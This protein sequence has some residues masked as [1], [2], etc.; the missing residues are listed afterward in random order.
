MEITSEIASEYLAMTRSQSTGG[1]N[2]KERE[3]IL[4]KLTW[5]ADTINL[6]SGGCRVLDKWYPRAGR[7]DEPW[8][9]EEITVQY[10][11]TTAAARALEQKIEK[12]LDMARNSGKLNPRDKLVYIEFAPD[13]TES[14]WRS[15]VRDGLVSLT[16]RMMKTWN[17]GRLELRLV[18]QR[19]NWWE[20]AA[21][22]MP[23]TNGN[24]TDVSVGINVYTCSA[25]ASGSS[26]N[27]R[28]D[29]VKIKA[30]DVTGDLAGSLQ[31]RLMMN[32][33]AGAGPVF[34][35]VFMG[36]SKDLVGSGGDP[37]GNIETFADTDAGSTANAAASGGQ[38]YA[39]TLG[40]SATVEARFEITP[41]Y[42]NGRWT[43][44]L[45]RTYQPA[46]DGTWVRLRIKDG[47]SNNILGTTPW[48]QLSTSGEDAGNTRVYDLGVM[49]LAPFLYNGV[50]Y[51][52]IQ[53]EV[54]M[55]NA[56]GGT[57]NLDAITYWGVDEYSEVGRG[58]TTDG[59][60]FDFTAA[61]VDIYEGWGSYDYSFARIFT[62]LDPVTYYDYQFF[63]ERI[64]DGIW[65][66]PGVDQYLHIA[67]RSPRDNWPNQV[68]T[69]V[70]LIVNYRPRRRNL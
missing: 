55:W 24:G 23:L 59:V 17:N 52:D 66:T 15:Q 40:T 11:G 26:P 28:N 42:L 39:I 46:P 38:Y 25:D 3:M 53:G 27:K 47:E 7:S 35:K 18:I 13:E 64:G 36:L 30:A 57:L 33:S 29:W 69:Y 32:G 6:N 63:T 14:T 41:T 54:E 20:G 19:M 16:S 12:W 8:V 48:V 70:T 68:T 43:R 50:P 61:D 4:L 21:A 9:E 58:N 45:L 37:G 56:A 49:R 44:F 62:D 67:T 5:N 10:T 65:L 2:D 60:G 22:A 1:R 51:I 31:A 34:N